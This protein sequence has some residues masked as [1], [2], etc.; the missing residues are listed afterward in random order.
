MKTKVVTAIMLTLF[1]AS[2][3]SIGVPVA[4]HT[5]SGPHVVDLIADGGDE[6]VDV[7][8]VL[9]WNDAD[10][11]YVKFETTSGWVMTKTYVHVAT[12]PTDIPQ[13]NGNPIPGKFEHKVD[14]DPP[15]SDPPPIAIPLNGWDADTS[16]YIAAHAKVWG[17]ETEMVVHSMP[18]NEIYG[19]LSSYAPVHDSAWGSSS[20]AVAA[21]VHPSWPSIPDAIWV[22]T[23]YLVE[24]TADSWRWLQD[25]LPLPLDCYP[26]SGNVL[27]ATSDNAE[28]FYFNG[29]FV[30]SDGEVQGPF[31]DNH[32]WA[33]VIPYPIDPQPGVNTL[34]FIFR[35]YGVGG[36]PTSN[37][38]GLIFKVSASYYARG[39]TAWGAGTDFDGKNW[40]TYFT[41]T[42]QEVLLETLT[43]S[44]RSSTGVTSTTVLE[45]G[46]VYRFEASGTYFFRTEGSAQGY[47]AD[48]EWALRHDAYGEGWTK[49]D[50]YP[51]PQGLDLTVGGLS[52]N[53]D[54]GD[55]DP[56]HIYSIEYVGTDTTVTFAIFDSYYLDNSGFLTVN[57]YWTG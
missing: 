16:L 47:L 31:I 8:D 18:G 7:G 26:I 45:T 55:F 39:E 52:V 57:I 46:K 35:N 48:A 2:M 53:V 14:H 33:T 9:V 37:P 50:D 11:L 49:G 42:V 5:E 13:K 1:L 38:T 17:E 6:A 56:D 29:V 32:E 4:A 54:W 23:A 36:S 15:E 10:N 40:A 22:S 44:A 51:N 3:L 27:L 12:D 43:V 34:D 41:Y 19:P 24:D 28:E 20:S 30:G 21:W 25:D